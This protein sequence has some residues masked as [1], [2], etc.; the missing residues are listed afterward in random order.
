MRPSLRNAAMIFV[1]VALFWL[2]EVMG[3]CPALAQERE[4]TIGTAPVSGVYFPAGGAVCRLI[5]KQR[6]EN[7]LRCFV[8][9]TDG[10]AENLARLKS[11]DLD[12]AL[13]Q[14]DWQYHAFQGSG[15]GVSD[16]PFS[17]LRA[18]FSLHP[19]TLTIVVARESE[20]RELK[21]LE[22]KKVSLGPSGSA[23]QAASELL[24]ESLGWSG[25]SFGEVLELGLEE[26]VDA[27]CAGLIDAFILPLTHPNGIVA[28]ATEGCL[29]RLIPV[30][31]GPIDKLLVDW[32]FY[33]RSTIPAGLYRGNPTDIQSFGLRATLVTTTNAPAEMVYKMVKAVFEQLDQLTRQH[34]ALLGLTAK[35]MISS[36]LSAPLHEGALLYYQE[37]GWR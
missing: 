25:D 24:V 19:Q 15:G 36:G 14:S 1:S 29:A 37:M 8:E 31:G 18:V 6:A 34:P 27:L 26:Q 23:V 10:S 13:L 5:N 22:D 20:I 2:W 11:E 21:H 16:Q 4:I 7:G 33:S 28:A 30:G 3:A 32:P 9:A 35:E 17:E 12:F